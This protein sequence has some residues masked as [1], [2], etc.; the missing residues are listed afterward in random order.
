MLIEMRDIMLGLERITLRDLAGRLGVDEEHCRCMLQQWQR[1]G[2]IERLLQ[3]GGLNCGDCSSC[4]LR[5]MHEYY[6]W[7][8]ANAA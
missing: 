2:C 3:G 4:P 8:G 5:D 6:R 7:V 1:H